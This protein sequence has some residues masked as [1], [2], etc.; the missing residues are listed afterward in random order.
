MQARILIVEDEVMIAWMIE[1]LLE[2]MGFDTIEIAASDDDA[3]AAVARERPALIVS[4]INLG[5]GLDGIAVAE[6][7]NADGVVP[8][9]FVSGY[10]D[11]K[12]RLRI[13]TQFAAASL[14]RKPIDHSLLRGAVMA[15]LSGPA[16]H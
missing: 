2:E 15:A 6:R 8:V 5:C 12:A 13:E 16:R 1:S 10:A 9:L 11:D 3:F 4:D 14:L 7:I